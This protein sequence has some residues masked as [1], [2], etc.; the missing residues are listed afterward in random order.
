LEALRSGGGRTMAWDH[1]PAQGADPRDAGQRQGLEAPPWVSRWPRREDSRFNRTE[2][3]SRSTRLVYPLACLAQRP[4]PAPRGDLGVGS[5]RLS[6]FWNWRRVFSRAEPARLRT[7]NG[8]R[9]AVTAPRRPS[10]RAHGSGVRSCARQ[11]PA[12]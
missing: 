10:L 3:L 2:A 8:R 4:R 1:L 9:G 7:K 11:G 5:P 12:G 6:G